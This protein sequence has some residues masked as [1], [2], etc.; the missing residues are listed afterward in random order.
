M[1]ED[2][3]K[4]INFFYGALDEE[5][6]G[7]VTWEHMTV[8]E[9]LAYIADRHNLTDGACADIGSLLQEFGAEVPKDARTIRKRCRKKPDKDNFHHF[10]LVDAI[11]E[12]VR[13]GLIG[14]ED[15]IKLNN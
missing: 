9:K 12:Q 3:K 11:M 5:E 2:K 7:P 8:T 15:V 14:A 10:G 4:K 1:D 6:L 13:K